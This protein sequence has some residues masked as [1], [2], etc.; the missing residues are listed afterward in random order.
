MIKTNYNLMV[1]KKLK[2]QEESKTTKE[3]EWGSKKRG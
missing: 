2:K 3:K 1:K